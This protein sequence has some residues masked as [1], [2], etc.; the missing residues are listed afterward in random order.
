MPNRL[1]WIAFSFAFSFGLCLDSS[2]LYAQT[3]SEDVAQYLEM[4]RVE[5]DDVEAKL[6]KGG[7]TGQSQAIFS[8]LKEK[9]AFADNDVVG[10][11]PAEKSEVRDALTRTAAQHLASVGLGPSD[12]RALEKRGVDVL[13][14]ATR[15]VSGTAKFQDMFLLSEHPLMATIEDIQAG[16]TPLIALA[17]LRIDQKLKGIDKLTPP[18]TLQVEFPTYDAQLT[19]GQKCIF[20]FSSTRSRSKINGKNDVKG[21]DLVQQYLPYCMS[22]D[23]FRPVNPHGFYADESVSAA[24]IQALSQ[25]LSQ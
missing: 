8:L 9:R 24:E 7:L 2:A 21:S 22:G 13:V 5:Y 3:T 15:I 11:T 14:S 10:T 20:F 16:D 17:T 18:S 4:K 12:I 23:M 25:K 1:P 6:K 19:K